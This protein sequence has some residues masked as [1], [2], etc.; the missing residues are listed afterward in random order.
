M[1]I[2][3]IESLPIINKL[4]PT[5]RESLIENI[6]ERYGYW[7]DDNIYSLAFDDILSIADSLN[8]INKQDFNPV[9]LK[10]SVKN[11]IKESGKKIIIFDFEKDEMD[12]IELTRLI[13]KEIDMDSILEIQL[14]KFVESADLEEKYNTEIFADFPTDYNNEIM[15]PGLLTDTNA[16]KIKGD[17][18]VWGVGFLRNLD[19]DY[20]MFAESKITNDWAYLVSGFILAIAIIIPF[21][22]RKKA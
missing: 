10:D 11:R 22:S 2:D 16:E 12:M 20:V 6:E 5:S 1:K 8:I 18:L 19:S 15:M 3:D 9:L 7:L 4:E 13:A 14:E 21:L 17:T